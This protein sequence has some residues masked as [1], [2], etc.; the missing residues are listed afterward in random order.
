M[1]K[2]K[3]KATIRIW[4]LLTALIIVAGT[5]AY[6]A[7]HQH[8]VAE[9]QTRAISRLANA[10]NNLVDSYV[11]ERDSVYSRLMKLEVSQ[12]NVTLLKN[13]EVSTAKLPA[14]P[15]D[16]LQPVPFRPMESLSIDTN[17]TKPR[18][19]HPSAK[20][21]VPVIPS[22]S[23]PPVS[24]P[25]PRPTSKPAVPPVGIP[26]DPFGEDPNRVP[27][28]ASGFPIL[29]K[30]QIKYYS[31]YFH[32]DDPRRDIPP[33]EPASAGYWP[34]NAGRCLSLPIAFSFAD[35]TLIKTS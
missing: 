34:P 22:H 32:P 24:T 12:Q 8:N 28:D 18:H 27:F 13:Y 2:E 14:N 25:P 20:P 31:T 11:I 3:R 30:D 9:R 21:V 17:H 4:H 15:R 23:T 7:F 16:A 33:Y 19:R 35:L 6:I 5:A 1:Y 10:V 26:P 29:T